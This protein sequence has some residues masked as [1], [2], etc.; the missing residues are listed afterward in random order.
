MPAAR[1]VPGATVERAQRLPAR[2]A[3]H[4]APR[5]AGPLLHPRSMCK[6]IVPPTGELRY[7]L[8]HRHVKEML[9]ESLEVQAADTDQ[10]TVTAGKRVCHY[11]VLGAICP[12]SLCVSRLTIVRLY[13][14]GIAY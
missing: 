12:Y 13:G 10:V 5:V 4:P 2:V 8:S 6:P 3:G 11:M 14:A 9:I 7:L 1:T